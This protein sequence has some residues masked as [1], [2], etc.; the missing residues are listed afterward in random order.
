MIK[1]K[2]ET[3]TKFNKGMKRPDRRRHMELCGFEL[4]CS[5]FNPKDEGYKSPLEA[6]NH[7]ARYF[8]EKTGRPAHIVYYPS[9][10]DAW[11]LHL[12]DFWVKEL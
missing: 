10:R 3:F 7:R 2:V 11:G 5:P 8:N 12:Y 1:N 9:C 6:A 4:S